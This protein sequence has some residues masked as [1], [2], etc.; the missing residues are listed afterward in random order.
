[1]NLKTE[2]DLS[3][4]KNYLL[5]IYCYVFLSILLTDRTT[6]TIMLCHCVTLEVRNDQIVRIR[7]DGVQD[8]NFCDR[9][10]SSCVLGFE[11]PEKSL[12]S[13]VNNHLDTNSILLEKNTLRR[14]S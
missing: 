11:Y 9:F 6:S 4:R 10:K 5:Q 7:G 12:T 14:L 13:F 3:K 8:L 2:T 1:M